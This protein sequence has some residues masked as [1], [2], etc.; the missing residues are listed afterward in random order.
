MS[1]VALL[2]ALLG[3]CGPIAYVNEVTRRAST[4]VDAA[5][6]VQADKY[7][8]YYWTRANQYLHQA[9]VAAA[10][11]DFQGANRFGKL[12]SEAGD[13]AVVEAEIVRKDPTKGPIILDSKGAPAKDTPSV[14]PAK[15]GGSIA[16]AKEAE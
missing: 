4:S 5:R 15:D 16:P 2:I 6:A 8:P 3:A 7:A 10:R 13:K 9:R 12:A 1:R 14:A 11:A